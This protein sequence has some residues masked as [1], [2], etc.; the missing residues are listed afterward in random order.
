MT[1]LTQHNCPT[2]HL[3]P[4]RRTSVRAVLMRAYGLWSTRRALAGLTTVQLKDVGLTADQ[5]ITEARRPIWD[6]PSNWRK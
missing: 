4:T 6:V 3:T 1:T 5:A 2:A